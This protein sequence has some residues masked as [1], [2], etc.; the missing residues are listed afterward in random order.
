MYYCFRCRRKFF[1]PET[2]C[3]NPSSLWGGEERWRAC[4]WCT[5]EYF[6]AVDAETDVVNGDETA[7]ASFKS[8]NRYTVNKNADESET[9][10]ES[11]PFKSANRYTV[12]KNAGRACSAIF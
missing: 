6:E 10:S 11:A 3:D 9:E 8:A 4:P 1:E 5:S 2:L 12:N 7:T